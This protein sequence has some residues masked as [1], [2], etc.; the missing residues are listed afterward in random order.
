MTSAKRKDEE[1]LLGGKEKR[2]SK[3]LE[4]EEDTKSIDVN[5]LS[6]IQS[7]QNG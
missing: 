6:L 5:V 3:S 7:P 2:G 1:V 4:D